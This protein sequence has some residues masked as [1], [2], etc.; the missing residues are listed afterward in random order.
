MK[1]KF[2]R[3]FKVPKLNIRD[4]VVKSAPD[5]QGIIRTPSASIAENAVHRTG[6]YEPTGYNWSDMAKSSF[7]PP[8]EFSVWRVC[9]ALFFVLSTLVYIFRREDQ[10]IY[11]SS[12][13]MW[14]CIGLA[15]TY[16]V[17]AKSS[18]SVWWYD[19]DGYD[20]ENEDE[21][22]KKAIAMRWSVIAALYQTMA[23]SASLLPFL[24][25]GSVLFRQPSAPIS[26]QDIMCTLVCVSVSI[27]FLSGGS[28]SL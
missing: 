9:V 5:G 28:F 8:K 1:P 13:S 2:G 15:S 16:A 3:T 6:S 14:V 4:T 20:E 17:L 25:L 12:F 26:V 18:L 19:C 27:S 11:V 22:Q 23:C 21:E 24:F 10:R 7:V